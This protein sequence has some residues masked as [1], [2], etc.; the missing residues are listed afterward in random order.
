[1]T[2]PTSS[3]LPLRALSDDP[4]VILVGGKVVTADAD[5]SIAEAVAIRGGVQPPR[6]GDGGDEQGEQHRRPDHQFG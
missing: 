2:G 3:P 5:F 6:Q 4:D 1:M